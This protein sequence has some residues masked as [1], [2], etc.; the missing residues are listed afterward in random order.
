MA[1]GSAKTDLFVAVCSS[2]TGFAGAL[3]EDVVV[4]VAARSS[5]VA[6]LVF[7][8]APLSDLVTQC[9]VIPSMTTGAREVVYKVVTPCTVLAGVACTLVNVSFTMCASVAWRTLTGVLV[10]VVVA[11]G[12]VLTWIAVTF[13]EVG[14]AVRSHIPS[15][16]RTRVVVDVIVTGSAITTRST[17]AFID[18]GF[19]VGTRPASSTGTSV[20]I[21]IIITTSTIATWVAC[22]LV[23]VGFTVG[24]L[25][26]SRTGAGVV[27]VVVITACAITTWIASTFIDV[28]FAVGPC[29]ARVAVASSSTTR[30]TTAARHAQTLICGENLS[31]YNCDFFSQLVTLQSHRYT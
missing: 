27:V 12:S 7:S 29:V 24:T 4:A 5:L 8:D 26:S 10:D 15:H 25:P 19:A 16:A 2:V 17:L 18:V 31:K 28:R 14:F 3:P 13:V 21:Y 9:A 22:T 20:I 11:G 6:V 30:P 23:D 1:P